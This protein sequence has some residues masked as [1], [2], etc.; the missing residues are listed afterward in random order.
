MMAI[1]FISSKDNTDEEWVI[2][3]KSDNIEIM[4]KQVKLSDNSLKHLVLDIKS[5]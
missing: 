4:I 2:H 5:V 1:S 3:S